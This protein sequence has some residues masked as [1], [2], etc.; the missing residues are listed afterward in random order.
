MTVIKVPADDVAKYL[1]RSRTED[2]QV[3]PG[4]LDV[5]PVVWNVVMN[6]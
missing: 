4:L 2:Q 1:R 5:D 3:V 6:A